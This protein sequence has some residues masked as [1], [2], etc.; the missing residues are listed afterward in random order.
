MS[1][2]IRYI[3]NMLPYMLVSIPVYAIARTV[4]IK[5]RKLPFNKCREAALLVFVSFLTGLASQTVIPKFEFGVNGFGIVQSGVHT[6]NL[7]PF[8]VFVQTY[9]DVFVHGNI[10][11]F[12]INFLGNIVI[13]MPIG[14]FVALL[15]KVS[16]KRVVATGFLI[17]LFIELSQLFL[18]RGT[19]VDDLILNTTGTILGLL[20]YKAFSKAFSTF[21][22][23]FKASERK[24]EL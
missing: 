3:I 6:T 13:F 1:A 15:W 12:L 9:N 8:K 7:I 5:S 16:G 18:A 24:A 21:S 20:I 23:K 14:F 4:Y 2:I 19:D 10:N 11:Y 17:S 22:A